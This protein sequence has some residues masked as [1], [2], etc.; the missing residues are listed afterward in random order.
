MK[1]KKI[2]GANARQVGGSHYKAR[3]GAELQH[4]DMVTHFKMDYF[5][6]NITKYVMR[7]RDKNGVQDLMKARHYIDKYIELMQANPPKKLKTKRAVTVRRSLRKPKPRPV[8]RARLPGR[9]VVRQ[10]R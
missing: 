3:G 5:Q 4:W 7:C 2:T 8:V 1:R 6:G 9:A 10:G